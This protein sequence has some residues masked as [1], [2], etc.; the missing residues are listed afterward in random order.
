MRRARVKQRKT[1]AV[2]TASQ[3]P[4]IIA[5]PQINSTQLNSTC[6]LFFSFFFCS[7][8]FLLFSLSRSTPQRKPRHLRVHVLKLVPRAGPS[9]GGLLVGGETAAA[10]SSSRDNV[11]RRRLRSADFGSVRRWRRR[12]VAS[13]D[14]ALV[15]RVV[16]WSFRVAGRAVGGSFR[17]AGRTV[18]RS[19]RLPARG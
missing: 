3:A 14:G 16:G 10:A 8:F 1:L 19:F 18:G 4:R 13:R 15:G 12:R 5:T 11:A 6:F 17:L 2:E 7:F 9:R